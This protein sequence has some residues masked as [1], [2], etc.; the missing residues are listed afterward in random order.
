MQ[1]QNVYSRSNMSRTHNN[2]ALDE[3][4]TLKMTAKMAADPQLLS[5]KQE[6]PVDKASKSAPKSQHTA[7][8]RIHTLTQSASIGFINSHK[9]KIA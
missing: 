8:T 7:D 5:L 1:M 4:L 2:L 9:L 6:P 3:A